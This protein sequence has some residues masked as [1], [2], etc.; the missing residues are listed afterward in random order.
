MARSAIGARRRGGK[1]RAES[2][3]LPV[4]VSGI[5]VQAGLQGM[6]P[7]ES[8][9]SYN[10]VATEQVL[11][12]RK[13]SEEW[14]NGW[15]GNA[16]TEI[17]Y[18]SS[19]GTSNKLFVC[20][21][22]G[23]YEATV[24]G[25]GTA[26]KVFSFAT[27]GVTAG[28]GNFIQFTNDAGAEFIFYADSANGLIQ[29]TVSTDTWAAVTGITGITETS[30]RFV[31][32]HKQRIWFALAE[33]NTGWY[34]A[35]GAISG[36]ATAFYF[37]GLATRG[38]EI[39]SYHTWTVD[40]GLGIDDYLI[41]ILRGGDILAWKGADPSSA[42][43]WALQGSWN[44]GSI[45]AGRRIAAKYG[46]ELFILC[47]YGV[48]SLSALLRGVDITD[49]SKNIT[50]KITAAIRSRMAIELGSDRWEMMYFSQEGLLVINSP[51]R[52]GNS[53]EYLQYVFNL[54]TQAWSFWRG[55]DMVSVSTWDQALY[56]GDSAGILWTLTDGRD[57]RK[58]ADT[59]Q[60]DAI[61]IDF[62]LLTS[63][64]R[65]GH[66]N[67]KMGCFV[68][69]GFISRGTVSY[70][71]RIVY[72]YQIAEIAA[73]SAGGDPGVSLWDTDLW[74][75]GVWAGA[76]TTGIDS[77]ATGIGRSL[78][79]AVRGSAAFQLDLVEISIAWKSGGFL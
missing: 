28:Y 62:S 33:S 44:V 25:D 78:A 68:R 24:Q 31:G 43:T 42:D 18:K 34:L 3:S 79:V 19:D 41:V 16:K 20:A 67:Y 52:P 69:P 53:D 75:T 38:G 72:D 7:D 56:F 39:V 61:N 11:R 45:P 23:I 55:L 26:T 22:D 13:G 57:N 73:V 47:G 10:M 8:L 77:G 59:E 14:N 76:G 40:G 29:Y 71:S 58:I 50:A 74:D 51:R 49:F 35:L 21:D 1:Q 63:F 54:T 2:D 17:P 65:Y 32:Q 66:A 9:Y 37:G 5:N 6:Q 48:I 36:A 27:A 64:Q 70:S 4:P 46:G 15:T 60:A 12:V 30:I